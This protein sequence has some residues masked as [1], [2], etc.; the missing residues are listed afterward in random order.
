MIKTITVYSKRYQSGKNQEFY[1]CTAEIGGTWYNIK[2]A[3]N[4]GKQPDKSGIYEV[5]VDSA[6]VFMVAP[7]EY[8]DKEGI[9]RQ[10]NPTIWVRSCTKL[11]D[12]TEDHRDDSARDI[13]ELFSK[14]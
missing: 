9:K 10:G 8:I 12:V 14:I 5:T 6:Q 7:D 4:A 2:F 11:K 1:R 13:E 3:R